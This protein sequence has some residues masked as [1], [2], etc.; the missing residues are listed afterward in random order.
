MKILPSALKHGITKTMIS[1]FIEQNNYLE[2]DLSHGSNCERYMFV[3][4]T[5]ETV[6]LIELGVEFSFE[7]NELI[8]FHADKA[9]EPYKSNFEDII[10]GKK[11]RKRLR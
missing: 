2:F 7:E 5:S 8:I 1:K 6:T 4:F 10:D 9:R 11:K 3:G